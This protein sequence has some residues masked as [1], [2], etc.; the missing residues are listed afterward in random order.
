MD[1]ETTA[2]REHAA[3][4]RRTA[5]QIERYPASASRLRAMAAE[6]EMQA[7]RL[8][9]RAAALDTRPRRRGYYGRTS[10]LRRG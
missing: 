7:A 2:L 1:K 8:Q 9:D 4:C 3:R 6:Y 10:W 5:D